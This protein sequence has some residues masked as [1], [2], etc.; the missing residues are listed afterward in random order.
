MRLF[1]FL[2]FALLNVITLG[3]YSQRKIQIELNRI[4]AQLEAAIGRLPATPDGPRPQ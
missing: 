4:N 3:A 2:G 1:Q